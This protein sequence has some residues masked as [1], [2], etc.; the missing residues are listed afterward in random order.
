MYRVS[1]QYEREGIDRVLNRKVRQTLPIPP[2]VTGEVEA[3]NMALCYGE[4]PE[5]YSQCTLRL[6]GSKAVEM[7]IVEHISAPT[8]G[9]ILKKTRIRRI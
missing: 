2:I 4:L 7:G 9:K 6:L 8:V 3:K 5:G 1:K